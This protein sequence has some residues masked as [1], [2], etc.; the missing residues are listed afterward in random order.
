[1][2][3]FIDT[4]MLALQVGQSQISLTSL[5]FEVP[6]KMSIN[7]FFEDIYSLT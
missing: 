7:L 1:M 4:W 5:K 2:I 6:H 3:F